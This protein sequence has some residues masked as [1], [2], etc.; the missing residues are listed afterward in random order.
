[1]QSLGPKARTEFG[2]GPSERPTG[3]IRGKP[4]DAAK[5]NEEKGP[6]KEEEGKFT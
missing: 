3:K 1:L 4:R 6:K 2:R 5:I